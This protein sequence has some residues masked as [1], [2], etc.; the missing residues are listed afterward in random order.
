M[1]EEVLNAYTPP[2]LIDPTADRA[3]YKQLADIIRTQIQNGEFRPGQRLPAQKDYMYEHGVSRDTVD[4][5]MTVLRN[6]GLIV[7]KRGGSRVRQPEDR[8]ILRLSEG[9]VSARV[10]TEPERRLHGFQEGVS[11]FVI[12]R[13]GHND[14]IYS[15]DEVD[16]E[17]VCDHAPNSNAMAE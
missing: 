12:K 1:T 2:V 17:I 3:V 15:A 4:R 5:A 8:T 9:K 16:I 14:E 11:V 10:P 6:E 13:D 7:V